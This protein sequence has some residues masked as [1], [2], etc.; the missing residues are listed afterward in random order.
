VT[1]R[2]PTAAALALLVLFAT[3]CSSSIPT[4]TPSPSAR[5]TETETAT[6]AASESASPSAEPASETTRIQAPAG[7][8]LL[9][10][11]TYPKAESRCVRY[12]RPRLAARYPGT[13]SVRR[14]QDGTLSLTVTLGFEDYLEGIA[15]V[16]PSW[17]R[18]ALE[19]QAIAARS[20]ALA[21]TDW[22]GTQGETLKTPICA[23]TSCQVYRG[24]PVPFDPAVRRWFGAVRRTTGQVLLFEG[25][26]ADTVYFSTS[27]GH[28]YGNDEVFGSAPLPYLRPVV[29]RDDGASPLSHW[30]VR[31]PF[32]D[33]ATFLGAAGA[34]PAHR[35]V[36]GVGLEG[37][38]VTV[39]GGG[40]RRTMD[41]TTFRDAVNTWGPCLMPGRYPP[42]PLPVTLPS[43][44]MTMTSGPGAALAVGR[45][46][47]H[48][49]GM[50]QW[51]AYGKARRG[52]TAPQILAYYYGGLLPAP[53][54]EPGLIH[55]RVASGLT[56]LRVVPSA[57]G[58][59]VDGETLD[60]R[61]VT[62]AGGDHLSVTTGT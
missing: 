23:T 42:S 50:V 37:S 20:Y 48:G 26:P 7:A 11:G 52:L 36:T 43:G 53:F 2:T 1:R 8:T 61:S 28:T 47:G 41:L 38:T 33:V 5:G 13:L 56:S 29:E 58:A 24:I 22:D 21:T 32:D 35:P 19:A 51:G 12:H 18:A 4:A 9:V 55:V 54:P 59:R 40:H 39:E 60:A 46:W 34:W 44:W 31:L 14:A 3:A 30:R 27:N 62:I 25:R 6:H 16:P 49:V 57:P 10:H 15:E 45:G 17:P